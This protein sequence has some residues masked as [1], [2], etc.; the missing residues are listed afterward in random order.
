MIETNT[1]NIHTLRKGKKI[2]YSFPDNGYQHDKDRANDC[3]EIG[4][5]YT[6]SDYNIGNWSSSIKLEESAVWWFNS[7]MFSDVEELSSVP[8]SEDLK[9]GEQ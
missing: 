5:V 1:V 3:L 2:R 9:L 7:V 6:V 4:H 8:A